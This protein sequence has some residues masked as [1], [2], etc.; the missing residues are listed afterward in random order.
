MSNANPG[1]PG[2]RRKKIRIN[3]AQG[4]T[5]HR[6]PRRG[7]KLPVILLVLVVLLVLLWIAGVFG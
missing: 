7:S 6:A 4:K 5:S 1:G 3:K 2:G